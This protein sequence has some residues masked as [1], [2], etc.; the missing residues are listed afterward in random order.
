MDK[1]L[2]KT[3]IAIPRELWRRARVRAAEED[4]DFRTV[5][6]RALEMYLRPTKAPKKGGER[7]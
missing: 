7:R 6:M 4:A 1:E 2:V 3:T 5:V